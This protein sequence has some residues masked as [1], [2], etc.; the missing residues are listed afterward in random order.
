MVPELTPVVIRPI[1][2]ADDASVGPVP[3]GPTWDELLP[4]LP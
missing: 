4:L 2:I 3:V 1:V